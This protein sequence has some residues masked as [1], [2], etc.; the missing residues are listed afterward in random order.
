MQY[1]IRKT[2][3]RAKEKKEI[4]IQIENN[5]SKAQELYEADPSDTN[6][7]SLT[8]AKEKLE[9][10]YEEKRKG[11]IIRARVRWP[12]HGEKSSKYFLNLEKRNYVKKHMRNLNIN[13]SII[14]DA[15]TILSEQKRFYHTLYTSKNSPDTMND[16]G[17][18]L[19]SI[20][21]PNLSEEQK[22]SCK[23]KI[24]PEECETLLKTLQINKA[25]GN[26]GIPIKFY[27][28]FWPL[29]CESFMKCVNECFEKGEMSNSQKQAVITLIEKKKGKDRSFLENWRPISLVNVDAKIMLKVIATRIKNV[30]PDI[31]HYNQTGFVKDR[32]IGQT[33]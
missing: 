28:K 10:F 9:L 29:I 21:I 17:S 25:P 1:N 15:W 27:K 26:E 14:T 16:I 22:Q 12:E 19:G 24:L 20:N 31:T 30:L 33:I 5:Y 11:I 6:A 7:A 4:E 32:Y 3:Q 23:G 8:I 18:F 2:G 13:D